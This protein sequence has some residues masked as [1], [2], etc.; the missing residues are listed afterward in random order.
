MCWCSCGVVWLFLGIV[1]LWCSVFSDQ[2]WRIRPR[3][4]IGGGKRSVG[5]GVRMRLI[6]YQSGRDRLRNDVS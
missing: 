1:I 2:S 6:G 4:R 3:M 5:Q